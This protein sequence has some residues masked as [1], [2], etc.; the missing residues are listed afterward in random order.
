MLALV[1]VCGVSWW[2][3]HGSV[4]KGRTTESALDSHSPNW[5]PDASLAGIQLVVLN[6]T[7]VRG[8]ARDCGML[9][10]RLGLAPVDFGN[11]QPQDYSRCF[12]VNRRLVAGQLAYLQ[13]L[14]GGV[15]I[16]R[17]FDSRGT[18]DV[19]LVLGADHEQLLTNLK[20]RI[21]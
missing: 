2:I 21:P 5:D 17:E 3:G 8:L 4:L 15:P 13:Q 19:V 11:A 12:L 20:G 1:L 16:L 18:E 14:L 10:G 7:H 6:G 9:L